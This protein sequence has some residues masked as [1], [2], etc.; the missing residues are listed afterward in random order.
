MAPTEDGQLM[1]TRGIALTIPFVA[2]DGSTNAGKTG[3]G[4]NFTLRWV[5]DGTSSALTTTTVTEI[6]STNVPGG[7][8]Q[9]RRAGRKVEHEQYLHPTRPDSI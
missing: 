6:D 4:S 2:W 8:L 5:K 1:A 9:H 3:D 7:R